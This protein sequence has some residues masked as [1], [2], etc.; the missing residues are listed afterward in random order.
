MA[1]GGALESD[2]QVLK[3]QLCIYVWTPGN[4]LMS[5]TLFLYL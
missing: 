5:E 2:L 3:S 1:D 4:F